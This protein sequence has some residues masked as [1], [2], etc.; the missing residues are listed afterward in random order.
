[1]VVDNLLVL[2]LAENQA[3]RTGF[4]DESGTAGRITMDFGDGGVG[5]DLG[6]GAGDLQLVQDIGLGFSFIEVR[7]MAADVEPLQ[8]GG[9]HLSAQLVPDLGL[10][11]SQ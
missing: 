3:V 2:L 6:L 1:M 11:I 10:P 5:E 9:I 7:K 8:D 4:V